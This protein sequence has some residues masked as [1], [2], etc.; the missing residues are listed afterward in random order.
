MSV[1]MSPDFAPSDYGMPRRATRQWV[2][3]NSDPN[4]LGKV[5]IP[6]DRQ[7]GVNSHAEYSVDCPH[8]DEDCQCE[9]DEDV[10]WELI[11]FNNGWQASAW[12]SPSRPVD[13]GD[14][15]NDSRKA[16]V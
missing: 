15:T 2:A 8:I 3:L 11:E 14:C 12:R 6:G 4:R 13:G 1:G 16:P 5:E 7:D 10:E 9:D